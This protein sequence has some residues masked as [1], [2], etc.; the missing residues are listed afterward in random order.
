MTVHR[1]HT[2]LE[3]VC[4]RH[5]RDIEDQVDLLPYLADGETEAQ[6]AVHVLEITKLVRS[7]ADRR[8]RLWGLERQCR[9]MV[10]GFKSSPHCSRSACSGASISLPVKWA[11]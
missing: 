4:L 10:K 1:K 7:Q 2:H 5:D 3:L 8:G 11:Q 9:V 6:R